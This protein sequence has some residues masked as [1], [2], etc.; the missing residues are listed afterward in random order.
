MQENGKKMSC[1]TMSVEIL[2]LRVVSLKKLR[3]LLRIVVL[4][5]PSIRRVNCFQTVL[6]GIDKP[7]H[8][9]VKLKLVQTLENRIWGWVSSAQGKGSHKIIRE[10]SKILDSSM[11]Q[12][13]RRG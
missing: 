4:D 3:C 2:F 11:F 8:F 5:A 1:N 9:I 10:C 12:E 13:E 7:T 6:E